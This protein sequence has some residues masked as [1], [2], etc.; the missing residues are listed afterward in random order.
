MKAKN[1]TPH[2][3]LILWTLLF[4]NI[5]QTPLTAT[6]Q[7]AKPRLQSREWY[8]GVKSPEISAN[9]DVTFR[10]FAPQAKEVKL[11]G[12]F[13][14]TVPMAWDDEEQAWKVTVHPAVADIY[15]YNFIVDGQPVNDPANKDLFPNELFK[16]SLLLMPNPK[17]LY[18]ERDIPHGK[19]HYCSY[20][21]TVLGE[22]RTM[23]V[24][25]PAE[26]DDN[27]QQRYPVLYLVS[28]TTDTEE[29]WYKAGRA[30]FI[31]DNLIHEG[32]ATPMI[33]V[34]PYGNMNTGNPRPSSDA[35]TR[36]YEI[37]SQEMQ[38]CVMPY[39]ERHYR[40][41]ADREHRAIAGFSRGGGEA[42][43]TAF[44]LAD[45]FASVCAYAAYLTDKV[46]EQHFPRLIDD[47]ATTN[48]RYRLIWFG[49]GADDFLHDPVKHNQELFSR[50]G[51]RY[52]H[53][54]TTGGHTWMNARQYLGLT[55]P[56]LFR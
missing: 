49:V 25:T 51:I 37:F 1:I 53:F 15:P 31:L 47:P 10:L 13:G 46:Y 5:V 8:D 55:L 29:T 11:S 34:M 4:L 21:S 26:Y 27:I 23:L 39:V 14:P 28:G 54:D 17:M 40:T 12:Q 3:R 24:Y 38:Q 48:S 43:F 41:L 36:C 22:L 2:V 42:L 45:D 18:T 6:A 44:K 50:K 56:K 33:V 16:G 9:G 20:H 32:K 35:A 52:E 19:V 30:N 7:D